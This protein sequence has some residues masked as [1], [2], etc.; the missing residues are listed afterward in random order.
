MVLAQVN[1]RVGKALEAFLGDFVI[2][3]VH[4]TDFVRVND[5]AIMNIANYKHWAAA[6]AVLDAMSAQPLR[7]VG[8]VLCKVINLFADLIPKLF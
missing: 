8:S 2:V 6:L 4:I 3:R 7:G 5:F 1:R